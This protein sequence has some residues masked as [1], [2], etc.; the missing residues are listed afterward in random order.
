M[1]DEASVTL[2]ALRLAIQIETEGRKFYLKSAKNCGN[3]AGRKLFESLAK[4]EATHRRDFEKIYEAIRNKNAWPSTRIAT[5]K[6]PPPKFATEGLTLEAC[7][8]VKPAEAEIEAVKTAINM[9]NDSYDFYRK[10]YNHSTYPAEKE[11]YGAISAAENE[12]RLALV[13]YLEFLSDPAAY[14]VKHERPSLD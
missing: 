5:K 2:E 4:D 9:E 3:E 7:A 13:D 12:H 11:F 1:T 8:L 6:A 14:F 10:Q